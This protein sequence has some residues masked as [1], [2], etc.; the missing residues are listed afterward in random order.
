MIIFCD[1]CNHW[2]HH[3][4]NAF[5][6]V[7]YKVLQNKNESWYCIPCTEEVF[8]FCHIEEKKSKIPKSLSKP[9]SFLVKPINQLNKFTEETKDYDE[10]LP[11]RQYRNFGYLQNFSEIFKSKS[12]SSLHINICSLSKNFDEFCILLKEINVNFNIN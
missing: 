3:T 10:N 5:S 1:H 12:L 8:P 2:V 4:G 7:E 11:N 9:S 6:D